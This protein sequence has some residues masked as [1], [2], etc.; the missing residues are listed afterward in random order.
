MNYIQQPIPQADPNSCTAWSGTGHSPR[1][2]VSVAAR[3]MVYR[4]RGNRRLARGCRD[5]APRG[6]RGALL[7]ARLA[8]RLM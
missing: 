6:D 3:T 8:G 5:S 4:L 2:I 1:E 7:V